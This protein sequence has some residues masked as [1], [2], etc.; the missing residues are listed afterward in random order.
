MYTRLI[1]IFEILKFSSNAE[2]IIH[3]NKFRKLIQQKTKIDFLKCV[4]VCFHK[5]I[6]LSLLIQMNAVQILIRRQGSSE[7]YNLQLPIDSDDTI[8]DV[9]EKVAKKIGLSS[10]S[11]IKIIFC[12]RKLTDEILV[13]D[14]KLGPQT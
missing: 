1:L 5:I 14:L 13:R 7:R 10:S 12:G 8:K 3:K 11:F 2:I 9:S 4:I 6:Y